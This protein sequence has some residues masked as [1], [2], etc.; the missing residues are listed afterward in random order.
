MSAHPPG[1][2]QGHI[3]SLLSGERHRLCFDFSNIAAL[4]EFFQKCK[5]DGITHPDSVPVLM[6][7][8]DNRTIWL[9]GRNNPGKKNPDGSMIFKG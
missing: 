1:P 9:V 5:A 2:T 8:D 3:E 4:K 6:F 7:S